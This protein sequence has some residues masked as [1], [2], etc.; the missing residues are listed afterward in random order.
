M[1]L[2]VELGKLLHGHHELEFE[3]RHLLEFPLQFISVATEL[4]HNLGVLDAVNQ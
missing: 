1:L 4:L 3:P 2:L